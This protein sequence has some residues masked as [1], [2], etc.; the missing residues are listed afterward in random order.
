MRNLAKKSVAAALSGELS[1]L[2]RRVLE[3]RADGGPAAFT[4]LNT[5][6]AGL[7]PMIATGIGPP[8]TAPRLVEFQAAVFSL[9]TYLAAVRSKMSTLPSAM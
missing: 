6:L 5:L 1:G 3:L 7:I 2:P 8:I 4:K 9:K